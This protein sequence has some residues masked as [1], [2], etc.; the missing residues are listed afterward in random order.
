MVAVTVSVAV[1][2]TDTV[3][4]PLVGDVGVCAVGA[5]RHPV[6]AVADGMVVVTVLVAVLITDTV[7]PPLLVT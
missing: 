7:L 6:R 5:D 3:L 4:A 1:L 2:I